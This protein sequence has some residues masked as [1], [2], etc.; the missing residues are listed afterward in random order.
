MAE[1]L[2]CAVAAIDRDLILE[3]EECLKA[4]SLV[5]RRRAALLALEDG[6]VCLPHGHERAPLS[7]TP[8]GRRDWPA[9][10][11][12]ERRIRGTSRYAGANPACADLTPRSGPRQASELADAVHANSPS[13]FS[14]TQRSSSFHGTSTS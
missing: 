13:E 3:G 2:I 12:G 10:P 4:V 8:S 6:F 7:G 1:L 5:R 11:K 9:R 14:S